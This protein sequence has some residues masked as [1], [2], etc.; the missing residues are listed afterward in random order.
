MD[1]EID[2]TFVEDTA[3]LREISSLNTDEIRMRQRLLETE[4]RVLKVTF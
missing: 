2:T 3:F 1:M 4:I